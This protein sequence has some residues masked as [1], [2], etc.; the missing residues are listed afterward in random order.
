MTTNTSFMLLINTIKSC[1]QTSRKMEN[2]FGLSKVRL[3]NSQRKQKSQ[4]LIDKALNCR[5]TN[6]QMAYSGILFYNAIRP[7]PGR[8]ILVRAS[9]ITNVYK[10]EGRDFKNFYKELLVFKNRIRYP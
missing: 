10:L 6:T 4:F 5:Q 2:L 7:T 9:K 3:G 8:N 1:E